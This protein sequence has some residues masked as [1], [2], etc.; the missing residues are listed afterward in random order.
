MTIQNS[1]YFSIYSLHKMVDSKY[2]PEKYKTL[3]NKYWDNK[4]KC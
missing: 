3:K 1:F 4:K 2:S